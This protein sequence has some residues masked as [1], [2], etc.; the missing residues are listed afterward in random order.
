LTATISLPNNK[1]EWRHNVAFSRDVIRS[2]S[3]MPGVLKAA[4]IQ[5]VPMRAG[6]FFTA[7]AVEGTPDAPVDRPAARIRVVSPGI[8]A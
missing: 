1:F 2:V 4:V 5:G 6:S 7:F 3:A 8:S